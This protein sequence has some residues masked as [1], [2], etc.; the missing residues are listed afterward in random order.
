MLLRGDE[1]STKSGIGGVM[2]RLGGDGLLDMERM[3]APG[4]RI[5]LLV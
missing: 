5:K 1:L 3:L 2:A 4:S